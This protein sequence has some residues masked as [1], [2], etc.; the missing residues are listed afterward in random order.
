MVTGQRTWR[1]R[2]LVKRILSA[3]GQRTIN[4][5]GRLVHILGPRER[6]HEHPET[7]GQNSQRRVVHKDLTIQIPSYG[8]SL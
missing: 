6:N 3:A 1:V 4:E 7:T 2:R 8:I 5:I